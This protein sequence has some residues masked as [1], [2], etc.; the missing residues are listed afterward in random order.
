[1]MMN[2]A[3]ERKTQGFELEF[4]TGKFKITHTHKT[5]QYFYA[6]QISFLIYI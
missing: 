1:M 4:L 3:A 6:N 2:Y 5:L